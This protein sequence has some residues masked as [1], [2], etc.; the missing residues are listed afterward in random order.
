MKIGSSTFNLIEKFG[1]VK[2]DG[3]ELINSVQLI[4]QLG[5]DLAE[6]SLDVFY[7]KPNFLA[8]EVKEAL[9]NLKQEKGLT[10]SIHLPFSYIDLASLDE[11]IRRDSVESIHEVVNFS[12]GLDADTYI[13]HVAGSS[14]AKVFLAKYLSKQVKLNF[15]KE[16]TD[17]VD[18]SISEILRFLP[19]EKLCVENI[20]QMPPSFTCRIADK[21]GVSL[22]VDIGHLIVQGDEDVFEFID[23]FYDKIKIYHLHDVMKLDWG[24]MD[25][26]ALGKGFFDFRRFLNKLNEK[27]YSGPVILELFSKEDTI[28]SL[29]AIRD[30]VD[31]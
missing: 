19:T 12:K 10:Y 23:R 15:L 24:L 9:L 30:L 22:C 5:L 4:N 16:I 25:H 17:V 21:F 27:Q 29:N 7:A 11:R 2:H 26:R 3:K 20:P 18:T 6:L 1:S 28:I 13:L 14:T 8:R 31:F